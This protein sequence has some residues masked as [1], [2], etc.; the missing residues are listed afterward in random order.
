MEE[1]TEEIL[2]DQDGSVSPSDIENAFKEVL[3]DE[4]EEE[5]EEPVPET[6]EAPEVVEEESNESETEKDN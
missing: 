3:L 2:Q 6:E 4:E 1:T 5:K